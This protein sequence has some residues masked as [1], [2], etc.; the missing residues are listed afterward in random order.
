MPDL[1]GLGLVRALEPDRVPFIVFV[2]A[3]DEFAVE[4]FEA[5]A[6]DYLVKPVTRDRFARTMARVRERHRLGG[7]LELT[8]QLTSALAAAQLLRS[9]ASDAR[10]QASAPL[11]VLTPSGERIIPLDEIDWIEADDYYA[12]VHVGRSQYLLRESLSSLSERLDPAAFL[13]VHRSAIVRL[14][15]VRA[16]T[17]SGGR[18]RVVLHDDTRVPVSRRRLAVL[19]AALRPSREIQL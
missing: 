14:E 18:A 15:R 4:A 16:I 8:E 17:G 13:R 5:A 3:H 9:G 7:A 12:R 19:R 6:I 10:Q 2:T 1:D 11:V